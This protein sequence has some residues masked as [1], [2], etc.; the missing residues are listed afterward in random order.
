LPCFGLNIASELIVGLEGLS[1]F[2]HAI[3]KHLPKLLVLFIL[4]NLTGAYRIPPSEMIAAKNSTA[5][6]APQTKSSSQ[7]YSYLPLIMGLP[8]HTQAFG[9]EIETGAYSNRTL[10]Q[11]ADEAGVFWVRVPAFSWRNIEPTRHEPPVYDWSSI[12]EAALQ[13]LSSLGF[14]IIGTIKYTPSWAQMYPPSNY[15]GPVA[16][17]YLDEFAQ[18]VQNLVARYSVPP[19]N[20]LYWEIGN[21]PDLDRLI[22]PGD[23]NYGCWGDKTDKYYGGRYYATMLKSV[24]PAVKAA[25]PNAQL[26]IGGLLM[27]C[28]PVHPPP[29]KDCSASKF[30]EGILRGGGAPYFDIV[31]FHGYANYWNSF[32]SDENSPNW[33]YRGGVVLGKISFLK[34]M[35]AFF[36]IS[37]SIIHTEGSLICPESNQT[38]CNP[39][40]PEFFQEQA[41]YVIWL[42]VR[43]WAQGLIGTVWY[44]LKGAD[45]RSCGLLYNSLTPKPSYYAYQFLAQELSGGVY[46]RQITTYPGLRVYE[47]SAHWRTVWVVWAPD[48]LPHTMTLPTNVLQVLDK[49]GNLVQPAN[50]QL[51]VKSPVYIEL[52]P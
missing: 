3:I 46:K 49:Y 7:V 33:S 41:D 23:S 16:S 26:L 32:I 35:M 28:D 5:S 38:Q 42:F 44:D 45:W 40:I 19:Y 50:G 21:E 37:K 4:G 10:H 30:F 47:F 13:N 1:M 18:F 52:N 2:R 17:A 12:D 25:N 22:V 14:R 34:E 29:G 8:R 9:V 51:S 36:N 39:P 27:E 24:Y 15:C 11:R 43:N 31:G 6:T 20:I 48:E